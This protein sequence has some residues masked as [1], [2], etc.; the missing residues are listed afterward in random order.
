MM[1]FADFFSDEACGEE[2]DS[3][4]GFLGDDFR[5][6]SGGK[7]DGGKIKN[8]RGSRGCAVGVGEFLR[9]LFAQGLDIDG[10]THDGFHSRGSEYI[11]VNTYW[12]VRDGVEWSEFFRRRE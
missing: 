1:G 12:Q 3:G 4:G 7:G 6:C 5:D 11:H 2:I 8:L 10:W 9:E